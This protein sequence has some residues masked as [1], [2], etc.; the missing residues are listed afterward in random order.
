MENGGDTE[1]R[2]IIFSLTMCWILHFYAIQQ[3]HRETSLLQGI[4]THTS[5]F[6]TR[7]VK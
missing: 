6:S 2:K 7:K 4:D 3:K 5:T 1:I